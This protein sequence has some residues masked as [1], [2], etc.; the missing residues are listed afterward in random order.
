VSFFATKIGAVILVKLNRYWVS[1]KLINGLI[2]SVGRV[3]GGG[4]FA[5]VPN[6]GEYC[7]ERNSLA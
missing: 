4:V 1:E 3:S 5:N 6:F 2:L 7:C